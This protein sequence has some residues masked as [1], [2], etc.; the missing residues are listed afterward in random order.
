MEDK[1]YFNIPFIWSDK[2][3][4]TG[5]DVNLLY[6]RTSQYS[7]GVNIGVLFNVSEGD[8]KG[9]NIGGLVNVS[10]GDMKGVNG[11]LYNGSGGDMKGVNIGAYNESKGDMKGVNIG[12][13]GNVSEGDMKGISLAG[14]LNYAGK[15]ND[16][17]ISY[18]TLGNVVEEKSKDSFGLQLGL[19][20]KVGDQY[21]PIVNIW[22][23]KNIPKLIKK[24]FNKG[25]NKNLEDKVE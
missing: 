9:V 25:K 20:N 12:V 15:V 4:T 8:M 10:E 3:K 24:S 7:K 14:G 13:L 1:K 6:K 17:L 11:G 16:Y 18:G 5:V 23:V 22:G 21:S 19:Y 2:E